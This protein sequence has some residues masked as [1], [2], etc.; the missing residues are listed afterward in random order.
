MLP[1]AVFF[2]I[3]ANLRKCNPIL[4]KNAENRVSY[5]PHDF[6]G[7]TS[8]LNMSHFVLHSSKIMR[9]TYVSMAIGF[10]SFF[11]TLAAG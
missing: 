3:S 7:I 1:G 9:V 8:I 6:V 2:S 11:I 10:L 4:R 5:S